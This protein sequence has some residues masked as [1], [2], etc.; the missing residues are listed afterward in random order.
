MVEPTLDGRHPDGWIPAQRITVE[1][2][3]HA[4]TSG[5]AAT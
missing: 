3:L 1:E 5:A 2:A 4:Y